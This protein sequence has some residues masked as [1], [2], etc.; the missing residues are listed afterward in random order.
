MVLADLP[1]VL[2]R[3]WYLVVVGLLGTAMLGLA[4]YQVS[5]PSFTSSAE[6][7]LLPPSSA[8]PAG[9]NPYLQ[10]GG[11]DVAGDVL[12]KAMSDDAS[13]AALKEAGAAGAYTAQLDG[14]AAAPMVLVTA[15]A[16]SAAGSQKTLGLVLARIPTVLNSIQ[17]L[18]AAPQTARI[19][20]IV[21]TQT[22]QPVKNIKSVIRAVGVAVA[23]GLAVTLLLTAVVDAVLVRPRRPRGAKH[24]PGRKARREARDLAAASTTDP[25]PP[26]PPSR[27]ARRTGAPSPVAAPTPAVAGLDEDRLDASSLDADPLDEDRG[28]ALSRSM[29]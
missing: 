2:L 16:S 18:A 23:G 14:T 11:L 1:K 21:L 19:T 3:R 17:D 27:E 25:A 8:V 13:A 26:P 12:S 4:A 22:Q 28:S 29:R 7:L 9:G 5:P 6:V 10:L 15:E 24:R 20:T